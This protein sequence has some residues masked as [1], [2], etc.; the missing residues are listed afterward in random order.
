MNGAMWAHLIERTGAGSLQ[1]IS[2]QPPRC[3][4][5]ILHNIQS[6]RYQT[7]EI[8]FDHTVTLCQVN[9][10]VH[11]QAV[12]DFEGIWCSSRHIPGV[13]FPGATPRCQHFKLLHPGMA[14]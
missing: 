8:D 9:S 13:R 3:N 7:H 11:A 4:S 6:C 12:W 2:P 10:V 14:C 1:I 5:P